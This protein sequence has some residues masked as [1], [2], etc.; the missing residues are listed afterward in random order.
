MF[1]YKICMDHIRSLPCPAMRK[2]WKKGTIENL[3]KYPCYY[4]LRRDFINL[5]MFYTRRE[6]GGWVGGSTRR[7]GHTRYAFTPNLHDDFHINYCIYSELAVWLFYGVGCR[8]FCNGVRFCIPDNL[9]FYSSFSELVL[10]LPSNY[11]KKTSIFNVNLPH[12]Y[13]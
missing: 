2:T 13:F 6:A 3:I 7:W 9:Y 11:S 10:F 5:G 8:V 1:L 4:T 12:N